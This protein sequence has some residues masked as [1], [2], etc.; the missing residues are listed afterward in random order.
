MSFCVFQHGYFKSV[1]MVT[2]SGVI[3]GF[4]LF[5]LVSIYIVLSPFVLGYL[6]LYVS[7][8]FLKLICKN[9]LKPEMVL[10]SSRE[11]FHCFLPGSRTLAS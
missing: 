7:K 8:V 3:E 2:I 10:L 5:L 9:I 6:L 11:C 4:C 1:L